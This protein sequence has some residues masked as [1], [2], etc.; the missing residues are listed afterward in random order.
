MTGMMADVVPEAYK[1]PID[2]KKAGEAGWFPSFNKGTDRI[3]FRLPDAMPDEHMM[4]LQIKFFRAF[5]NYGLNGGPVKLLPKDKTD[6]LR[7]WR[8]DPRRF[9]ADS[10]EL[11]L[12]LGL[13]PDEF[14]PAQVQALQQQQSAGP[15]QAERDKKKPRLKRYQNFRQVEEEPEEMWPSRPEPRPESRLAPKDKA[16]ALAFRFGPPWG[17]LAAISFASRC[18]TA[19]AANACP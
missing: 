5:L 18:P 11:L 14:R 1:K 8:E 7:L 2:I 12:K 17:K 3:E 16:D 10:D 19:A 13:D 4:A 9:F 6:F 15:L